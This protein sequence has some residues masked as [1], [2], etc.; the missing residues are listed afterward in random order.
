MLV[1]PINEWQPS[2]KSMVA[3][4]HEKI[5]YNFF[6]SRST[7]R[8]SSNFENII[9]LPVN[10]PWIQQLGS[11][12]I[13]YSFVVCGRK[14]KDYI[15][16][17]IAHLETMFHF[18]H[19]NKQ[20]W[21]HNRHGDHVTQGMRN[22]ALLVGWIFNSSMIWFVDSLWSFCTLIIRLSKSTS[23]SSNSI[24]SNYEWTFLKTI[25]I[26][27]SSIALFDSTTTFLYIWK[28][29]LQRIIGL[30]SKNYK[31]KRKLKKYLTLF[32]WNPIWSKH[33]ICTRRANNYADYINK[34][35]KSSKIFN[36][37]WAF[38]VG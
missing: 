37:Q 35:A 15:F 16:L 17:S 19:I 20:C 11:D 23:L 5:L 29:D 30:Y 2:L 34:K 6:K 25:T 14:I 32:K 28:Q 9:C 4:P 3:I 36:I 21:P 24:Y 18:V 31:Y 13:L 1:H 7:Q 22:L 27:S 38:H 10:V 12:H 8:Y 26:T 33:N